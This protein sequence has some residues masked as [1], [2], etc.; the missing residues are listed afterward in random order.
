MRI[1]EN[2]K[3]LKTLNEFK[4]CSTYYPVLFCDFP[5]WLVAHW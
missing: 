5:K 4:K 1:A 2:Y 3:K